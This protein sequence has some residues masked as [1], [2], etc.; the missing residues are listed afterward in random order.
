MWYDVT[1]QNYKENCMK[2]HQERVERYHKSNN[3]K[4]LSQTKIWVPSDRVEEIKGI[5]A[6][7]RDEHARKSKKK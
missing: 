2:P 3:K 7:M 4:G 6:A 1:T 5:A